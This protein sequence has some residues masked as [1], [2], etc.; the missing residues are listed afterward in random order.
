MRTEYVSIR[1]RGGLI[2]YNQA[3]IHYSAAQFALFG[4]CCWL[5]TLF[6]ND[7]LVIL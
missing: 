7:I 5:F 3:S 4:D 6:D 1:A 2:G